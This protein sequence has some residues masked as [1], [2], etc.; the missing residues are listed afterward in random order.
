MVPL[1]VSY[2][3]VQHIFLFISVVDLWAKQHDGFGG[4]FGHKNDNN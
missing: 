4:Q 1:F 3:I 2:V